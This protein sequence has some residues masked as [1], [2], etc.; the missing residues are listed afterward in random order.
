MVGCWAWGYVGGCGVCGDRA[1]A[2]APGSGLWL[3]GGKMFFF[4]WEDWLVRK[5]AVRLEG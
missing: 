2:Y 5:C 4:Y 3:G 1:D